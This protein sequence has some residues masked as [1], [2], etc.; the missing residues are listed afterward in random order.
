MKSRTTLWTTI[1][2]MAL[3]GCAV[4]GGDSQPALDS[5]EARESYSLGH[6]IGSQMRDSVGAVDEAA[7]LDGLGDA[8]ADT[9]RLSPDQI[10]LA[11]AGL[12]ERRAEE[13]KAERVA[14]GEKNR[15]EGDAFRAAF[16]ENPGVVTLD[17][18][19]QYEVVVA[20]DGA[21]PG[22]DDVVTVHYRGSF[23]DGTEFDSSYAHQAPAE[24]EVGG[25][26]P[27][28]SEAL[29]RMP[30][31]STWKVVVP[32]DLAYGEAGAGDVIGPDSTLVFEIELLGIG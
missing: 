27:G 13:A 11:L 9:S 18:G 19:L 32:P 14:S 25:A 10:A 24:F 21:V 2:A 29:T 30:V 17:N 3:A 22:P 16:A 7:F 23:V 6:A 5:A 8:F 28:W 31:G 4:A 20:G 26:I 12:Q 1:G 15:A